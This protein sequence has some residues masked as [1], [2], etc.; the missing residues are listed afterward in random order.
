MWRAANNFLTQEGMQ[1]SGAV[2]FY[3]ILSVPPLLVAAFSIGVAVVGE[4]TAGD[5][6]NTQVKTFMSAQEQI[7]QQ[8]IG[9]TITSTGTALPISPAFLLFSGSRVFAS[10]VAAI[11][12]MWREVPDAGFLRRELVRMLMLF[13]TGVVFAL[14]GAADLAV[15][16]LGDVMPAG[17]VAGVRTQILPLAL[18]GAGLLAL[19]RH[20]V[21]PSSARRWQPACFVLLS[22]ASSLIYPPSRTSNRRMA[23]LPPQLC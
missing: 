18:M 1:W 13:T 6:L 17:V 21:R 19:F 3:L 14:A 10:L 7:V 4:Q 12:V 16:F 15:T 20:G 8:L 5:F 22:S 2:A 23:R 11:Y 9:R